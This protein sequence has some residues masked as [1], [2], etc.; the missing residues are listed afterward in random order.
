MSACA[1]DREF[2][3]ESAA[4]RVVTANG[5][6]IGLTEGENR[7]FRGIPYAK[8][9]VGDLRWRAPQSLP[10][11]EEPLLATSPGALCPQRGYKDPANEDCLTL[12]VFT[13]SV[14]PD[15]QLPVLVYIHGGAFRSG[16]GGYL[17]SSNVSQEGKFSGERWESEDIILVTSFTDWVSLG[18]FARIVARHGGR[19]FWLARPGCCTA[20]DTTERWKLRR[21]PAT[22]HDHGKLC[23]SHGCATPDGHARDAWPF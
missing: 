2:S 3:T 10:A 21:R 23:R 1:V 16:S 15:R 6:I 11:W 18:S 4:P 13:P 14:E 17:S 9:P 12:N 20:L 7:A 5:E 8:P 22:R 19:E